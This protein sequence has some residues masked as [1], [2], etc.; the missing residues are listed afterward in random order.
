MGLYGAII[1]EK[2]AMEIAHEFLDEIRSN[3]DGI[4]AFY[5]IGSLGGGYYRPGQSDIDTLIIVSNDATV[6]Q[7]EMDALGEKYA[8]MYNIPKGF[9]AVVIP[10]KHLSSP[11]DE[12]EHTEEVARLKTQG[13]VV[14]S[15]IDLSSL[16]M[17]T[18][19]D[20]IEDAL[21][22]EEWLAETDGDALYEKFGVRGCVNIIVGY[23][24]RYTAIKTGVFEF[25]KLNK[26]ETYMRYDPPM[27][28]EQ[29]F[30]FIQKHLQDEAEGNDSDLYMLRTFGAELR[31]FFNRWLRSEEIQAKRE[32]H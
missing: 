13:K 4:L 32:N 29:V 9:G 21:S 2:Q 17:P 14:Y 30:D 6:K 1:C 25:N 10:V 22:K 16:K 31:T 15:E 18:V 23:L 5:V 3:Y 20:Y 12:Y 11:Y 26:I 28:N 7:E 19:A 24:G 8:T 27:V